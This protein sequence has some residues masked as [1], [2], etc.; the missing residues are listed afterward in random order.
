M[1]QDIFVKNNLNENTL[2]NFSCWAAEAGS[3]AWESMSCTCKRTVY[4]QKKSFSAKEQLICKLKFIQKSGVQTPPRWNP[5]W[6]QT[7]PPALGLLDFDFHA[8]L[9]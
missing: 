8:L 2:E 6:T 4:L 5:Q 1:F 7:D 3:A 9:K